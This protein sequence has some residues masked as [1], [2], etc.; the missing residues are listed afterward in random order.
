MCI[1]K[2]DGHCIGIIR[3]TLQYRL[4]E[5]NMKAAARNPRLDQRFTLL[6]SERRFRRACEQIVQLNYKLDELQSR[7]LGA[8][9]DGLRTFRYNYRL[10]LSVIEG[11]RNMYYDYA[12]QKAEDITGLKMD[13]YGEIVDVVSGSEDED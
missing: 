8:K 12:H 11:L 6:E 2:I 10:R 7:Y 1:Y 9:T 3:F 13:L 4:T 5:K